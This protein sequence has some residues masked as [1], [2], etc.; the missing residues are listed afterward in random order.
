MLAVCQLWRMVK[1]WW[2]RERQPWHHSRGWWGVLVSSSNEI[3]PCEELFSPLLKCNNSFPVQIYR[4]SFTDW[5]KFFTDADVCRLI[6]TSVISIHKTWHEVV[7]FGTWTKNAE[8]LLNRCGGCSNHRPTFLQNPQVLHSL[9]TSSCAHAHVHLNIDSVSTSFTVLV[10]RYKG[11]RWS[12]NLLATERHEDPQKSW[13]RRKF[14]HWLWCLQGNTN[15]WTPYIGILYRPLPKSMA[16]CSSIFCGPSS[17]EGP[18]YSATLFFQSDT[19][20]PL[21]VHH[22]ILINCTVDF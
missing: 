14:K 19:P 11:G 10:W 1:S 5:C 20:L 12:P 22:P 7:H 4:M 16:I 15:L 2:Y 6:N 17:H 13:P 8:P 21:C 9:L 3:S 18:A